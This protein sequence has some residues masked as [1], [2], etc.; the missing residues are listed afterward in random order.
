MIIHGYNGIIIFTYA[1]LLKYRKKGTVY[2][3]D[4]RHLVWILEIECICVH[5][6]QKIAQCR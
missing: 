1:K 2:E 3:C 6:N 5:L 4:H